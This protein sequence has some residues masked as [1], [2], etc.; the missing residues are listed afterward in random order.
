MTKIAIVD[1]SLLLLQNIREDLE[2]TTKFEIVFT[3]ANG[4]LCL[5]S[6]ARLS[7]ESLP[8]VVLMDIS[9]PK[10]DGIATT[11]HIRALYPSVQVIMLTSSDEDNK[12]LEAIKA[13]AKGYLLKEEPVTKIVTAIENVRG[14]GTELTTSIARKV[15]NF[16]Q[17]TL[18]ISDQQ[19][20]KKEKAIDLLTKREQE[21]LLYLVD[22]FT[23]QSIADTIGISLHTLKRH[24]SNIYD[25]MEV[26]N[27]MQVI[28]KIKS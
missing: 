6:L 18:I 28:N 8:H 15:F 9:M 16:L 4:I 27:R 7:L 1:D 12:I 20:Q 19:T 22:G 17:Q 10:L 5:E 21:I 3:A 24:I 14:G 23:Y 11:T 13:G 25:K 26:S 2:A